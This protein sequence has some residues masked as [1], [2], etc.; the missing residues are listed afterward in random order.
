LTSEMRDQLEAYRR[1][2]FGTDTGEREFDL[3]A[4]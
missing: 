4:A 3:E 1:R 2:R